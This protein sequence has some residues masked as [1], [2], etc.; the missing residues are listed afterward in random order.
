MILS[1]S[2]E[3]NTSLFSDT[4][5]NKKFSS[6]VIRDCDQVLS[7]SG[8]GFSCCMRTSLLTEGSNIAV[9]V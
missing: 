2:I 6:I 3:D 9:A 5:C 1:I 8:S 7:I 4:E